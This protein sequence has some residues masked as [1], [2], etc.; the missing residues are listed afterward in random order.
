M[1]KIIIVGYNDFTKEVIKKIKTKKNIK[2]ILDDLTD[3]TSFE[4]IAIDKISNI[5]KYINKYINNND[6]YVIDD[7]PY[8][9]EIYHKLYN[10]NINKINVIVKEDI[11][12]IDENILNM[13]INII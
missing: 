3:D 6:I 7:M 1:K 11:D 2:I 10:N 9:D 4:G 5:N 12:E 8:F 13:F